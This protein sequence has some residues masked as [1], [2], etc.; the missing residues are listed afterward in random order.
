M[1]KFTLWQIL[2]AY[3]AEI[4]A[5]MARH[6]TIQMTMDVYTHINDEFEA[7]EKAKFDTYFDT[8]KG[9]ILNN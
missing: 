2:P 9:K 6:N 8:Q 3:C 4:N 1:Q 7:Q 5:A